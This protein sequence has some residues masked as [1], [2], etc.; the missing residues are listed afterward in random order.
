MA[1]QKLLGVFASATVLASLSAGA[2]AQDPSS[3]DEMSAVYTC[4]AETDDMARLACFDRTVS[5]LRAANASGDLVALSR[6]EVETVERDAF[7]FNMP[8]LPRLRGLFGSN[9]ADIK[10]DENKSAEADKKQDTPKETESIDSVMLTVD[11][12]EKFNRG[13]HRF[14]LTNGQVWYQTGAYEL[15]RPRPGKSGVIEVEI[16]KAAL[17]SY[18][19][20]VNGKGRPVRVRRS[21]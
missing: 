21:K 7:G 20:Q 18:L 3:P 11:R 1:Y 19:L 9:N 10:K 13:R 16:R 6:D 14:Y 17:G 5:T 2:F 12:L 8:S 15:P 4:Q